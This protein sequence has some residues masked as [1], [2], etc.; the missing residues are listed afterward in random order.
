M[1]EIN[2]R[3]LHVDGLSVVYPG[4]GMQRG[5]DVVAVDG[6]SLQVDEGE[7]V[8]LVGE[9]GSGKS[10]LALAAAGLGR[11]T[12]G[13]IEVLDQ[14]VSRLRR[15]RKGR[16]L[17]AQ[18]QMVFQ[19]P[20]GSLDPRQSISSGLRELRGLHKRRTGWIDDADLMD[21]VGLGAEILERLPHEISGGQAQRVSIARALLLRP[22][23]LVADEPTSG[24]DVSVQAQIL[25][26]LLRI[27]DEERI[28]ILFI[29]H[30]LSVVRHLC[31]RVHVMKD[32]QMVEHGPTEELLSDPQHPYTR[33]LIAAVPG[34]GLGDLVI[35]TPEPAPRASETAPEQPPRPLG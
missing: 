25:N 18:V 23:L 8:G 34:R 12:N 26:L 13:T 15:R 11:L 17:R 33:R 31:D 16:E 28:A 24:L 4:R 1:P 10:T 9:S 14:P 32:G 21:R 3:V 6:A 2:A 7:I 30:D 20:H 35:V 19:D 27:R 29:S 22:K 5:R